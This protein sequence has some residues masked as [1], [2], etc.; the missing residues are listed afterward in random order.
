MAGKLEAY[1]DISI[2]LFI[3]GYL[4]VIDSEEGTTRQNMFA[5]LKDLMSHA[6][7]YRWDKARTFVVSGSTSWN[8]GIVHG[9]M[10]RRS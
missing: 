5:H 8:R 10:R 4:I 1:Q 6:Q 3:Q 9:W 2:S 7:L